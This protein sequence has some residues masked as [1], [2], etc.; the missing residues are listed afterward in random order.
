[1]PLTQCFVVV[2][3][4]S[5]FVIQDP[6]PRV[7][8]RPQTPKKK[9]EFARFHESG[10]SSRTGSYALNGWSRQACVHSHVVQCTIG[11]GV[12]PTLQERE[13]ALFAII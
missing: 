11:K 2:G 13:A 10:R 12:V 6:R 3:T 4:I 8:H 5:R 9:C 7:H 1:M